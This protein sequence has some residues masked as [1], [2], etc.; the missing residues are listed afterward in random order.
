MAKIK[1]N[2][3]MTNAGMY[4]GEGNIYSLPV[5]V[6]I[7]AATLEIT[8]MFLQK[9][10]IDIPHAQLYPPWPMPT[11]LYILS[12]KHLFIHVYCCSV[13]NSQE[14]RSTCMSIKW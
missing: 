9:L 7:G 13:L 12:S 14:I 6:Q 11:G 3:M 10:E 8:V 2:Q 5:G 1:K 4:V